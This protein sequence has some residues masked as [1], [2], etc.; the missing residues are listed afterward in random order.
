MVIPA[1][2]GIKNADSRLYRD[3]GRTLPRPSYGGMGKIRGPC[4]RKW[5]K[6]LKSKRDEIELGSFHQSIR[7][8]ELIILVGSLIQI[9]CKMTTG[10]L[11]VL[12]QPSIFSIINTRQ[13]KADI[14]GHP[15]HWP[16]GVSDQRTRI[17][18]C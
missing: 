18:G 16:S 17:L 10:T 14:F 15:C 2:T 13:I 3:P 7:L 12:I 5:L 8:D 4:G 11:T 1:G 9:E 6:I